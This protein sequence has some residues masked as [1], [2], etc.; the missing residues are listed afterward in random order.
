M[1]IFIQHTI[2]L[3]ETS[4]PINAPEHSFTKLVIVLLFIIRLGA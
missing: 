2:E 1:D 3:D 4:N